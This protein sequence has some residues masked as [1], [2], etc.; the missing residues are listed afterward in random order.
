MRIFNIGIVAV[1]CL[2]FL[3]P[4]CVGERQFIA[5]QMCLSGDDDVDKLKSIVKGFSD[6]YGDEFLD[7]SKITEHELEVINAK[8]PYEVIHFAILGDD[9]V[10][11]VGANL[12]LSAHEVTI[13]FSKGR[14]EKKARTLASNVIQELRREW[15]VVTVPEG[16]GALPLGCAN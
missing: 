3:T 12:G 2:L 11:L 13:G 15:V 7:R 4:G 6:D 8:P 5:V 1:A 14:D 10:G 16:H 9:G